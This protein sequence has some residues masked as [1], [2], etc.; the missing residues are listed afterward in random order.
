LLA[1]IKRLFGKLG[2]D[3][4][5]ADD[6]LP[7]ESI[8]GNGKQSTEGSDLGAVHHP[9]QTANRAAESGTDELNSNE[10]SDQDVRDTL[11]AFDEN[12]LE[13]ARTQWQFGD[14]ESLAYIDR[15]T[16][17]HHPER[18]KL[19][20]LAAAGRL[21]IGQADQASPFIRLA[22]DWGCSPKL[23][24]QILCSGV[25]NSL[26]CAAGLAGR[27]DKAELSFGKAVALG[28]GGADVALLKTA[29]VNQQLKR[30][31]IPA[32]EVDSFSVNA[33]GTL[34]RRSDSPVQPNLQDVDFFD[35][36][37]DIRKAFIAGRWAYLAKLDNADV[38]T[39]ENKA[40]LIAYAALGYQQL[41]DQSNIDRCTRLALEWGFPRDALKR[42]LGSG[43]RNTLAI[44]QV[45][46]DDFKAAAENFVASLKLDDRE[47]KPFDVL[48]RMRQQ[49]KSVKEVDQEKCVEELSKYIQELDVTK[50]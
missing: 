26:G 50:N 4:S 38:V 44:A 16:L 18:A 8:S 36:P 34:G 7:S 23:V 41:D 22:L 33:S 40:L 46:S 20:L 28:A 13:K 37:D 10:L 39:R 49:L 42:V 45:L 24:A 48:S 3:G 17:Q 43:I 5:T 32:L 25:Y 12:L 1:F 6:S 31:K 19:A 27:Q 35:V 47:P 2:I 11:V 21:Q 9:P 30:I 14:W 29:R 15:V